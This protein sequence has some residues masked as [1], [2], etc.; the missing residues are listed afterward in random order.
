MKGYLADA[1]QNAGGIFDDAPHAWALHVVVDCNL[2]T[3]QNRNS[4]EVRRTP[5]SRRSHAYRCM[6]RPGW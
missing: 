5:S 2:I 3:G 4:T 1:L 6:G